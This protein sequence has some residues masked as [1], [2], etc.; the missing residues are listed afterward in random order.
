MKQ[1]YTDM[2]YQNDE[3]V[4][5]NIAVSNDVA[6]EKTENGVKVEYTSSYVEKY[7]FELDNSIPKTITADL[8]YEETMTYLGKVETATATSSLSIKDNALALTTTV[9]N[10][11]KDKIVAT[12]VYFTVPDSITIPE[13]VYSALPKKS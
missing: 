5:M 10:V 9:D 3:L 2:T 12:E 8:K 11:V 4:S 6:A 7:F 1:E 13:D